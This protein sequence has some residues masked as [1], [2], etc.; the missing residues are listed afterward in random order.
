MYDSLLE[1]DRD[2][3]VKP[4]LALSIDAPDEKTYLIKLRQGVKFHSGQEVTAED[5][6]YSIDQQDKPRPPGQR[7]QFTT[8]YKSV[9]VVDKYTVRLNL[10]GPD[11]SVI[12]YFA[13]G[14]YSPVVPKGMLDQLNVLKE[15]TGTGPFKLVEYVPNDRVEYVRNPD[16]WKKDLPYLDALTLKVMT[17]EQARVAALRSGAIDG[18]TISADVARTLRDDTNLVTLKG[19]FAAHR[20]IQF[21]IKKGESKPWHDV[22]VRQAVDHAINRQDIADKVYG[23]DA[24]WSGVIPPGYG[25]WP[26]PLAELKNKFLKFDVDQAKKLMADAGFASGFSV[27]LESIASPRDF[28]QA[29]EV[30]REHLKAI[31]INVTVR[32]L[33]IGQ[34][35]KN[36]GDGT[37]EWQLTGRGMRGDPNGYLTEFNPTSPIFGKWFTGWQ[38]PAELPKLLDDGLLTPDQDKRKAL[39]R[40]AQEIILTEQVHV[41]LVQPFKYQIVRKRLKNMY[42]NYTDFNTGLREVWIEE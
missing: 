23:G 22:R 38:I 39:Y 7:T 17:D 10:T 3:K 13:W 14:R 42:V 6:A 26:I 18:A 2:L 16:F 11:P 40:K 12:G 28:T 29:A 4:A 27:T 20:E 19:L 33:E 41:T 5:V 8:K 15:G 31:N 32:P 24:E 9:D 35:A 30:V 21:T 1:W 36:N 25:D 37:Y 34:F